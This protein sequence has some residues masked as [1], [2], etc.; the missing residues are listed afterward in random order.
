MSTNTKRRIRNETPKYILTEE[1]NNIMCYIEEICLVGN[2]TAN[3]EFDFHKTV[4]SNLIVQIRF[5]DPSALQKKYTPE[6]ITE[7]SENYTG[8]NNNYATIKYNFD[9]RQ[10][11]LKYKYVCWNSDGRDE[12][13]TLIIENKL[14]KLTALLNGIEVD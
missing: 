5:T 13:T 8:M 4:T 3:V 11:E 6:D 1:T 14:S 12:Y 9:T 7:E 10:Y 2:L